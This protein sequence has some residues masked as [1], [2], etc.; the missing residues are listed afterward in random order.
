MSCTLP[1]E[2]LA[3]HAGGDLPVAEAAEV[4]SHILSCGSCA[5]EL[6]AF[7]DARAA[8]LD[9]RVS[10]VPSLSLWSELDARLDA[11]DATV[12]HRRP[13]FRR[14]GPVSSLAAAAALVLG[15]TLYPTDD[16]ASADP[17]QL[18]NLVAQDSNP[19]DGS[20]QLIPASQQELL[21]LMFMPAAVPVDDQSTGDELVSKPVVRKQL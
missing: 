11:V 17:G 7:R 3:L 12:R 9:L 19:V 2:N 6:A 15:F 10:K 14:L 13:W 16:L 21:D 5:K 1:E 20:P 4:E 18:N 8:L